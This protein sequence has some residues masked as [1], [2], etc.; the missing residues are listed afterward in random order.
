[1]CKTPSQQV[2]CGPARELPVLPSPGAFPESKRAKVVGEPA[3]DGK[4][5]LTEAAVE[6]C[7]IL[8]G[9]L[10]EPGFWAAF[11]QQQDVA[12]W[13][14]KSLKAKAQRDQPFALYVVASQ[15]GNTAK[16]V[17]ASPAP[18]AGP[19]VM[20]SPAL[21]TPSLALTERVARVS[22]P[23]RST[24]Q[25]QK[26]ANIQRTTVRKDGRQLPTVPSNPLL[27]VPRAPLATRRSLLEAFD[28]DACREEGPAKCQRTNQRATAK[29]A[30]LPGMLTASALDGGTRDTQ[31]IALLPLPEIVVAGIASF[32][33][34]SETVRLALVNRGAKDV[35]CQ[36]A[37]FEPLVLQQRESGALLRHLRAKDALGRLP[38][39]QCPVP[40][41][42]WQAT[43][44]RLELMEADAPPAELEEPSQPQ[45]Q[46]RPLASY[47]VLDPLDELAR[48]LRRGYFSAARSIHLTNIEEA[49]MDYHF[50]MVRCACLQ[51]FPFVR[52]QAKDGRYTLEARRGPLAAAAVGEVLD[53]QPVDA[54]ALSRARQPP[55]APLLMA[56]AEAIGHP[57]E[58]AFLVENQQAFKSGDRFHFS[59]APWRSMEGKDVRRRYEGVLQ[60]LNS[61][62]IAKS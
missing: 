18:R 25:P 14:L 19:V 61:L 29:P 13:L 49:R 58:V 62:R 22:T 10:R 12:A 52:T 47:P 20:A 34:F 23:A 7:R 27:G 35:L 28:E 50:L 36:P 32:L 54:E 17:L 30:T 3:K 8:D 46:L 26:A 59:H 31:D 57:A 40:P 60:H 1:M 9:S 5:A 39:E 44:V 11:L 6:A 33:P 51:N 4:Q 21:A 56:P 43:E 41:A 15:R 2:A 24:A 48:R 42:L 53:M 16:G 37:A 55:E 38:A 45:Q